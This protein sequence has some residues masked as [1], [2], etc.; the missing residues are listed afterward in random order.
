MISE[1]AASP[2]RSGFFKSAVAFVCERLSLA[3]VAVGTVFMILVFVAVE[4]NATQLG[5]F[6][7][8]LLDNTNEVQAP[9]RPDAHE[10]LKDGDRIDLQALSPQQRFEL[11]RGA[12]SGTTMTLKVTR[13][14]RRFPQVITASSTDSSPRAK[15]V[16][17]VGIPLCF[18]LSLGLASALFLMR[19]RSI[20]LAF[21][22]YTILML[23]KVN[24]AALDL[25]IWP[26]NLRAD[27]LIQVVFPLAQ[28]MIMVFAARL[29][30]VQTRAWRWLAGTAIF[31]AIVDFLVWTDPIVWMV[32]Q[33]YRLPGPTNLMMSLADAALILVVIIG[34][35]Y[36]SSGANNAER[37]RRITWIVAGIAIAPITDLLWAV[38]NILS[39]L[40]GNSSILLL[41]VQD[42]TTALG[43]WV[44]LIGV[45][46]VF[47]AFVSQRVVDIRFVIGRAAVY[48]GITA[49]LL[50]FF[51]VIEWW[52][53]QIFESTR[54]AIYVSLF[55][56]LFIGFSLNAV[57]E[58]VESLLNKV[59]F[60]EQRRNERSLRHASRAL[61]N[62]NSEKTLVEFL[63]HEPVRVLGLTSAALFL[64][65]G[66]NGAFIRSADNGWNNK[67]SETIDAEDPLIVELRADPEPMMLDGRPR[68]ET[69][70]PVGSKA[71]SLVVPLLVRG[72][73]FGFVFY[74]PRN[75]EQPLTS[76]ERALLETIA[77]NAGAAY[78]HIDADR[79]RTR[80]AELEEK[81]RQ[82]SPPTASS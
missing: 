60:R 45:V 17:D 28:L 76:D 11:I 61:A 13:A 63:V 74:G 69:I 55:A 54:P 22:I 2:S 19:P 40:V 24:K 47:Y 66:A 64:A 51:G 35:A 50:L 20:T 5:T 67:E 14:G 57:H 23:L 29:Y 21:Y 33:Q 53:E 73:V 1:R 56:A 77:H 41:D 62:T 26:I 31:F 44:G 42:W 78:D 80:I 48:V 15:F 27:L 82:L 7:V 30:G 6:P 38:A 37:A 49:V 43:P 70:L 46:F 59:F 79:A 3:V 39:T 18:F 9:P 72:S 12:K 75:N 68:A 65:R 10:V 25:A 32:F 71:P 34:L 58:H 36:I 52:A 81:L 4:D 8:I 16:R